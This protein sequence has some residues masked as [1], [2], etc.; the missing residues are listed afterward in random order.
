[1]H[2]L[3]RKAQT[4]TPQGCAVAAGH[5]NI[6]LLLRLPFIRGYVFYNN[7]DSLYDF[8]NSFVSPFRALLLLCVARRSRT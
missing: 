7:N 4:S 2:A 8:H 1:M 3:A 5:L 6:D